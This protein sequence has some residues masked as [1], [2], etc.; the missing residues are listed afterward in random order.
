M[1]LHT[2]SLDLNNLVFATEKNPLVYSFQL[3]KFAKEEISK[4]NSHI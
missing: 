2:I 3:E 4:E 1:H